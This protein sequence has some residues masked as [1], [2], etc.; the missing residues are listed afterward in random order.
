MKRRRTRKQ[1]TVALCATG[2]YITGDNA[3][4]DCTTGDYITGEDR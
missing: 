4:G 2:N 1:A 3:T